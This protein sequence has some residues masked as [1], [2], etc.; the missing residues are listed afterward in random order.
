MNI[1][2]NLSEEEV[3][4]FKQAFSLFDKNNDGNI[5][6]EELKTVLKALGHYPNEAELEAMV[7]EVDADGN[8]TIEFEEFL[9]MMSKQMA[10]DDYIRAAFDAMDRNG[11][12]YIDPIELK[13]V[14]ENFGEQ[15]SDDDV[16]EMIRE[17]DV[18]GDGRVDFEEF[19]TLMVNSRV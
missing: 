19:H 5:T 11:D 1:E 16:E 14:M 4:Q 12:G 2:H 15:L 7:E 13:Q 10:S 6:T 18:D 9:V 8:G 17:A 3:K